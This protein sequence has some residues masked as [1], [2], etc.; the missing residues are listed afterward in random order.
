M[1]A[2]ALR[3][4]EIEP[5]SPPEVEWHEVAPLIDRFTG[6]SPDNDRLRRRRTRGHRNFVISAALCAGTLLFLQLL[7]LISIKASELETVRTASALDREIRQTSLQIAL[8]QKQLAAHDSLPLLNRWASEMGYKKATIQE[9]DD[10][11]SNA[12]FQ[13]PKVPDETP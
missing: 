10:V 13:L 2:V 7:I 1:P 5:E 4:P 8:A 12:R 3:H 6:Q 9:M 11:T